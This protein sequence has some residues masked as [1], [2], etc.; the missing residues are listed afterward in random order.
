MDIVVGN[1]VQLQKD[2]DSRIVKNTDY[3]SYPLKDRRKNKIDRRKSS[4][5]GVF[6]SLSTQKDRRVRQDRRKI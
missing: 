2:P 1:T 3:G 5:E 4:R 6:V